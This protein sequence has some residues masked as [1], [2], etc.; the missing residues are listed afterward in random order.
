MKS[1]INRLS[2]DIICMNK[3]QLKLFC[4]ESCTVGLLA[5][6][7]GSIPKASTLLWG[8]AVAYSYEA[9][10]E[11][12]GVSPELLEQFGAVSEQ[13]VEA[14]VLGA[15]KKYPVS[16]SL[17]ISGIAGP[18]GG[19]EEKPVGLVYIGIMYPVGDRWFTAI[20][21]KHFEGEREE[22]QHKTVQCALEMLH[23]AIQKSLSL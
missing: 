22:I 18:D 17:A 3:G 9:K 13:V 12:T 19:T 15:V 11:L 6:T 8:G 21:K 10:T 1:E 23:M 2:R 7:L 16:L 5:S 4:A 20:E 14:M